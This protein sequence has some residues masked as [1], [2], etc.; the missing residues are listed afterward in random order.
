MTTREFS[1]QD[2][3][4]DDLV[5]LAL[6]AVAAASVFAL[7][8]L[9]RW[10]NWWPHS[11]NRQNAAIVAMLLSVLIGLPSAVGSLSRIPKPAIPIAILTVAALLGASLGF[12]ALAAATREAGFGSGGSGQ[13][14]PVP[15]DDAP[16]GRTTEPPAP[17]GRS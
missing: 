10:S 4:G 16:T 13:P 2:S 6:L 15:V 12:S 9:I 11:D 8:A 17:K 5:G 3:A 7:M 1:D 14:I